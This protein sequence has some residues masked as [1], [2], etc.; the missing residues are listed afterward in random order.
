[1][2]D[3]TWTLLCLRANDCQILSIDN[4]NIHW[5]NDN[6]TSEEVLYQVWCPI[7]LDLT[8]HIRMMSCCFNLSLNF[9]IFLGWV[10]SIGLGMMFL[11]APVTSALCERVG[12]RVVAFCGGLLGVLGFVL[13]SFVKDVHRLYIT[14]GVLWGVGASMSYLPTLRSLPYWFERQVTSWES[15]CNFVP[16]VSLLF[17]SLPLCLKIKIFFRFYFC[18]RIGLANGIVTAGSGVGTIAMGPL[19]QLAVNYLGWA[20]AARVLG[21]ILSLCT[22]GSLLHKVPSQT[23]KERNK[24]KNITNQLNTNSKSW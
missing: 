4:I 13:S 15:F 2:S 11:F 22:I 18:R 5:W 8:F 16:F 6:V 17:V 12:C 24:K 3:W 20:H 14:F 23:D 21:G 10:V 7:S 1:M 19:M 9:V